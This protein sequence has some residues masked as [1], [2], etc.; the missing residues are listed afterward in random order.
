ML[1]RQY[2]DALDAF[3]NGG[4][5][6]DSA[7]IAERVLKLTELEGWVLTHASTEE[8]PA[9]AAEN[10]GAESGYDRHRSEELKQDLR[11]LL[12]RRLVRD[13]QFEKAA[14]FFPENLKPHYAIYRDSVKTGFDAMQ[15]PEKRA[16][17]FW[18]AAQLVREEGLELMGTELNPD[19]HLWAG[20]FGGWRNLAAM[21]V[22]NLHFIGGPFQPT[23]D[24]LERVS[25]HSVPERRFHYRWRAAELAWWAASLLP[26]ESEETAA[27]LH[28]AGIWLK[29]RD[30][31]EANRFYQ[32]IAIRCG[33]TELGKQVAE[34]HW[35]LDTE[36]DDDGKRGKAEATH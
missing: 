34:R 35:F 19:N 29:A 7:Y 23:D 31:Q 26:N 28:T 20:Q 2:E 30:P 21:R 12:A 5:W 33:R 24:E 25:E 11:C 9:A 10:F 22:E 27:I 3:V 32:A 18:R 14:I 36:G 8:A 15:T 1:Q 16:R 13:H 6:E 17:A 4:H